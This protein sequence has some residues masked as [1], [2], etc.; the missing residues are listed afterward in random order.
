MSESN[1]YGGS[2][3]RPVIYANPVPAAR[4]R[5]AG[6]AGNGYSSCPNCGHDEPTFHGLEAEE[7]YVYEGADC[8]ECGAGW[9]NYYNFSSYE[10]LEV[11]NE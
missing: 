5:P 3:V 7:D 8:P 2:P 11:P 9:T 1:F 10:S 4:R 6:I